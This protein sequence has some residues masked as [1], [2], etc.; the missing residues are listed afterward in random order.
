MRHCEMLSNISFLI[1]R[2]SHHLARQREP[3]KNIYDSLFLSYI[4][5]K[6]LARQREP[7]TNI[8]DA[9]GGN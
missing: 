6:N 7:L 2:V 4:L 1:P 9:H 3:L 8:Y 5:Q